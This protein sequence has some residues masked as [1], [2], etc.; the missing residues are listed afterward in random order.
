LIISTVMIINHQHRFLF[1][2]IQK[3]GG[4]SVTEA[5]GQLE[6]SQQLG[7]GHSMISSVEASLYDGY[8][9][10]CFVRNPFERLVSWWN[11]MLHKGVHNDFSRYLLSRSSSFSEFL[12]CTEIIYE[13]NPLERWTDQP[14]PKSIAFNQLDY[15]TVGDGRLA[16]NFIGRF[17]CLEADFRRASDAIGVKLVLPH[18]NAFERGHYRD[19]YGPVETEK[20]RR[21]YKRD[22][23]HFGYDF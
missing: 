4:T 10:F 9:V 2:H 6:G 1:V 18:S 7:Y 12:D 17:E 22:L 8:F 23:D 11:M 21:L 19:Y 3:T 20:V 15:I 5:L 14:Y 16:L 13:E